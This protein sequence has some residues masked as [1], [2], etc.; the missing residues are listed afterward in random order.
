[1]KL[2]AALSG[3][4]AETVRSGILVCMIV[5]LICS[6]MASL[7]KHALAEYGL[8]GAAFCAVLIGV[9]GVKWL[10]LKAQDREPSVDDEKSKLVKLGAVGIGIF[11]LCFSTAL[12][13]YPSARDVHPLLLSRAWLRVSVAPLFEISARARQELRLIE[14]AS[15]E[16]IDV[17][18]HVSQ[19]GPAFVGMLEGLH[20]HVLDILYVDDTTPYRTSTDPQR[21]D[22]LRFLGSSMGHAQLCTTFNPFR[23]NTANFTK[24]SIDA[25]N[26]DFAGGA[27]AAKIWKNIG[28]EIKNASG[29]YVM[30]DDPLFEPIYRDIAAHHKSL[31]AHTAEPDVA[32][33]S[34]GSTGLFARYYV[35]NPQ[36]DMSRKPGA[37]QKKVILQARDHLLAMN[38]DLRVVGAH[39]GS[40]ENHLEDIAARFDLYPNFAVDTAAR[41]P[42]LTIQPRD[43]VRAFILKYQDRI[44]Y[45]TDLHFYS[46]TTDQAAA[47]AW[48]NRYALDW[49][50][51]A[52][53]DRFEYEGHGVEGLN[54][55][56]AVLKKLYH[57]NAVRWI[58]GIDAGFH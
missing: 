30:P 4:R 23:I 49:R 40:M 14:L 5:G 2:T 34:Q 22:A 41:V 38:P 53:D 27:V 43:K 21:E 51:F 18:T 13:V 36:W 46:G 7:S 20:M 45:G 10:I 8:V 24:E 3:E 26:E 57:Q 37:P 47:K 15:L 55:P 29:Q 6:Y 52:T 56:H 16:P 28:M 17:H 11:V 35:A 50:Y 44:L 31:I 54:L 33:E 39:L 25:L 42:S 48:E 9:S 19:T 58:P 12:M 32:W 1:V